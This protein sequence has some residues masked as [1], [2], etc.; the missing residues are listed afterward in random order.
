MSSSPRDHWER[1]HREKDPT[2]V[3]WYQAAPE[4]SLALLREIGARRIVDIGSGTSVLV[5]ELLNDPAVECCAVDVAATALERVRR[6]LESRSDGAVSRVRFIEADVGAPI[7][8]IEP[9]WAD[10]WHDR[11]AFHFLTSPERERAYALNLARIL[12][13]GG[14]AVIAGFAPDGPSRCS[15]LEVAR[16]D[17]ESIERVLNGAAPALPSQAA[18][19]AAGPGAGPLPGIA[20]RTVELIRSEREMHVTPG[21]APQ[22]FTWALLRRL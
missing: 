12:R 20:P 1:V 22:A 9:G 18:G 17:A 13:P 14:W 2:Q 10:A 5:D 3:S 11:A 16:R 15:G 6:R 19:P 4:R 21:G 8:G 7:P